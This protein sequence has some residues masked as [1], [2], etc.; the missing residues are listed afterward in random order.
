M[1]LLIAASGT[2]GHLFPALAVA[3]ELP[4]S[5]IEW[6]GVQDRLEQKLIAP[7][8]P[9]HT[10]NIQ[11]LQTRLSWKSLLMG[12]LL[13]VA[14]AQV[15]RLL[16]QS[17]IDLVFT[18][19]G[20]IAAP[21][22]L[23]ARRAG[24]PVILH[25]SNY[26]PGK[27]T[28]WLGRWCDVVALGFAATAQYLPNCTTIYLGNP[29]RRQ[30]QQPPPL[31]LPV[32]TTVPLILVMGGSQGA[33]SIND[34]VRQAA[35][36]WFDFGAYIVHLT[37]EKDSLVASLEH[38]QYLPL[39]F[40]DNIAGLLHRT[41]LAIS[42][43]G[44]GSLTELAI[45][46]TPAILIPYPYAAEDHQTYNARVFATAGAAYSIPQAQ[47]TPKLLRQQVLD[48][49][50]SPEKLEHMSKRAASLASLDSAKAVANLLWQLQSKGSSY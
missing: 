25:E 49:L 35:P 37:G 26:L 41:T 5:H 42:R 36:A 32:P 43:A 15:Y 50:N 4:Q 17:R 14:T 29:V 21:A 31:E 40:Y 20:Y 33:V 8:Y 12:R 16:R 18:T 2:G 13:V 39:P 24:I 10:V 34:L 48:L 9:L 1:R 22:I 28:G 47:L 45:T 38:P 11:G 30:F 27:V 6:L 7:H 44:S 3:E 19:G 46:G 23:A